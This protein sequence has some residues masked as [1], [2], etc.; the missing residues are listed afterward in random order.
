MLIKMNELVILAKNINFS[1]GKTPILTDLSLSITTG[2]IYGIIGPSGSGKTTLIKAILGLLKLNSG[3]LSVF[4]QKI[5]SRELIH[6]GYMP[7]LTALY[8]DLTVFQNIDFFARMYGTKNRTEIIHILLKQVKLLDYKNQVIG[9]L[10]GGQ[11]QRVSLAIALVHNPPLIL[12][13]EPTVGLDPKL[14]FE[15]WQ[16]FEELSRQGT[17]LLISSHTMDDANHCQKI[18]FLYDGSIVI[19]GNPKELCESIGNK[20]MTLE[21]VFLHIISNR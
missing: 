11:R 5:I 6:I 4:G 19:E 1:Y 17:T 8:E 3:E 12:L 7:Q 20:K 13:D 10:S 9:K 21:E 14:R 2:K 18:G 16:Y 15:L